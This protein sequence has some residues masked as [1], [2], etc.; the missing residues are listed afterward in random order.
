MIP[1]SQ[2]FEYTKKLSV[3]FVED[4]EELQAQM[5]NIFK[6]LF[7]DVQVASNGQIGIDVYTQKHSNAKEP[8]DLVITDINMPIMNG[9]D[10]I[11]EIYEIM[12]PDT[13]KGGD[14]RNRNTSKANIYFSENGNNHAIVFNTESNVRLVTQNNEVT[15][16]NG[17]FTA[18][19]LRA[20]TEQEPG[21]S[22]N[23]DEIG[24]SWSSTEME[25]FLT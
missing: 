6:T 15:L 16:Q 7:K 20:S 12:F 24:T 17:N 21:S 9:I 22:C 4:N 3:L 18:S 2:L 8:F 14:M 5:E 1:T 11:K 13:K 19:S 10:M 25:T 23:D